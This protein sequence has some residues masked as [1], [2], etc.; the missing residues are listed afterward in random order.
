MKISNRLQH[1][2][3]NWY[4]QK[5]IIKLTMSSSTADETSNFVEATGFTTFELVTKA[6]L[7]LWTQIGKISIDRK[8]WISHLT[9]LSSWLNWATTKWGTG[10][11]A[12]FHNTATCL[13]P[14]P[15]QDTLSLC[16]TLSRGKL[17]SSDIIIIMVTLVETAVDNPAPN[18]LKKREGNTKTQTS[19]EFGMDRPKP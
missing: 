16:V 11:G 3:S 18:L 19:E 7:I 13:P 5:A 8:K 6:D 10:Q 1:H 17:T 12:L 14:P 9:S 2:F 15:R 4:Y